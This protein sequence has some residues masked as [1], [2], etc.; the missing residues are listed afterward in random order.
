M[1]KKE[2]ERVTQEVTN[3]EA[4]KLLNLFHSTVTRD[5]W[6]HGKKFRNCKATIIDSKDF[7]VLESYR[8]IVA[9]IYK[10]TGALYDVLRTV[11]GNT[12]TSAQHIAKFRNDYRN[13]ILSQYRTYPI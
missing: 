1:S 8:T 9:F 4:N 6:V 13:E 7:I 2:L 3:D 10:P 11:Y 12:A 5:E